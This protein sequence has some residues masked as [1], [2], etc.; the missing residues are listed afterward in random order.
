[1]EMLLPTPERRETLISA[2]RAEPATDEHDFAEALMS[3]E[4]RG[5]QDPSVVVSAAGVRRGAVVADLGCGPGFFTIP[6]AEAVGERG[7]VFAVD[8]SETMLSHLKR[9]LSGAG[10]R[11][12]ARVKVVRADVSRTTLDGGGAD[13]VLFVNV[14]H[15]LGDVPSFLQEVRRILKKGGAAVDV[16]WRK[17]DNGFGPP[18]GIRLSESESRDHLRRAGFSEIKAFEAGPHHYG[19]VCRG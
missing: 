17:V 10:P 2:S 5:W 7:V 15:D 13:V 16:D 6:L 11:V 14:M 1:M 3:E 8:S 19:F 18:V 9:N 4:R 12:A